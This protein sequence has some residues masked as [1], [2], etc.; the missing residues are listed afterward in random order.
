MIGFSSTIRILRSILQ[1]NFDYNERFY[2]WNFP[3]SD[4]L[5]L[6][7][8][9][10][11][12]GEKKNGISLPKKLRQYVDSQLNEDRFDKSNLH[13]HPIQL[14]NGRQTVVH[15]SVIF[16]GEIAGCVDLLTA[17]GI[18]PAIKSGY[19][20]AT[21]L[22]ETLSSISKQGLKKYDLL[23]HQQIGKDF[24]FARMLSHL[25]KN[26]RITNLIGRARSRVPSN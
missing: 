8:G 25:I 9:G 18:R 22:A 10:Y 16:I 19:L 7:I 20:A 11:I 6:G 23:F 4:G 21:V 3:K 2:A 17:E 1:I 24:Q 12:K 14:Y 15:D 13:G 5:S 26:Y